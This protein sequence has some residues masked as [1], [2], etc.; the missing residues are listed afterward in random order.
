MVTDP[1]GG[2]VEGE[3]DSVTEMLTLLT[4]AADGPASRST[5]PIASSLGI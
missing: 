4:A 5:A 1:P 2:A 3:I